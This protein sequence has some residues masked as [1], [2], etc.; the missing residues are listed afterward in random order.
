MKTAFKLLL[1]LI[2]PVLVFSS[3]GK[4]EPSNPYQPSTPS[5]PNN[6]GQTGGQSTEELV[7]GN[8]YASSSYADYT[9]SFTISST[10]AEKLPGDRI[11]YG[12]GHATTTNSTEINV[13]V[14]DQAYY[15]ST[16]SNGKTE[17]I[18]I[19]NPFWFY[20]L[21]ANS[22]DGKWTMCE[23]Y[24][25]SYLELKKKGYSS[26]S[27][28]ERDLYNTAVSYLNDCQNEAKRYYRPTL[29]AIVNN[30]YYKI[31]SYQIP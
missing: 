26:L 9:F 23:R 29:Y 24:Y 5:E 2:V 4:D 21:F 20:Y 1:A 11:Q 10:L 16:S 14:G 31:Q 25:K 7:R 3:C 6:P 30:K 13:S 19:K 18:T 15:Y 12:V 28:D 17:T 22:D 8:V 27:S